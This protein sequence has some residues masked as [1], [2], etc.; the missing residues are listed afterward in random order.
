MKNLS[1]FGNGYR[2]KSCSL[3]LLLT[4]GTLVQ[5]EQTNTAIQVLRS[6]VSSNLTVAV[7]TPHLSLSA[8][9][10]IYYQINTAGTN[11]TLV[12]LP[13]LHPY[14]W[15]L[16]RVEMTD[17]D[18]QPL[19]KT[20]IAD[21]LNV[22]FLSHTNILFG[23]IQQSNPEWRKQPKWKQL[24]PCTVSPTNV[25]GT[26]YRFYSPEQLF[27]IKEPGNYTLKL[28]FQ[29]LQPARYRSGAPVYV[30]SFPPVEIPVVI[31]KSNAKERSP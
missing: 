12:Y 13:P 25:G 27:L 2:L 1:V 21:E 30:V 3:A 23:E 16:C 15:H 31:G 7:I 10:L 11:E 24:T 6:G 26:A 29:V 14:P 5:A 28:E 22:T 18:G 4:V 17:T 9:D 20:K 8:S 19:A